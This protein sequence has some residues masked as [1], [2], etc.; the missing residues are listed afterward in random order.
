MR[1]IIAAIIAAIALLAAGLVWFV[2]QGTG[3]DADGFATSPGRSGGA[4][5]DSAARI[6]IEVLRKQIETLQDEVGA[7]RDQVRG[8]AAR[9]V[10][11][12]VAPGDNRAINH[13][14]NAI[15]DTYAQV[16]LIAQRRSINEGLQVATPGFLKEFLGSPRET[17]SD[18]C[19][20]M[21]NPQLKSLLRVEQVGPVR[22]RMLQPALDSLGRVLENVRAADQDLYDRINTA[23]SLCVRQIRGTQGRVSSHSF[24][25]AV[26]LNIDGQ[27]D[28]LGDGK[29][30]LG[31]TILAD[32]FR[33]EGW[34]WGAGFT[35]ED[36]MHFEISREMLE[37]WRAEGKI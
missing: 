31:L 37:Q 20:E 32:F 4:A 9:P 10:P 25:L 23:G 7:L 1:A 17:L 27:L 26:D 12:S 21:T 30:Q 29:T 28:T 35:R 33:E 18:S 36:S 19:E 22:V 11:Q 3:Q 6:E 24:G 13:G 34:I 14:P 2:L 15:I 8:L 5:V 16:V